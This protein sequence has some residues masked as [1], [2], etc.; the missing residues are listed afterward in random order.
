MVLRILPLILSFI[1][2]G[3]HYFRAGN[4]M[5]TVFV[6][7]IPLLLLIKKSWSLFLVQFLTYVGAILW[8]NIAV[9]FIRQRWI[10]DEPWLRMSMILGVVALFTLWAGL[11][12][13]SKKI[14]S[15]YEPD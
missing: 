1:F 9:I 5:S 7:C 12:L 15:R 11:L 14:Y 3:A 8:V 10:I 4:T 2:L 13:N 6:L